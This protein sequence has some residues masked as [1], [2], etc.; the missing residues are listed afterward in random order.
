MCDSLITVC[1][2]GA[3]LSLS[4]SSLPVSRTVTCRYQCQKG[5]QRQVMPSPLS[6]VFSIGET[7]VFQEYTFAL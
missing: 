6:L 4:F 5:K 2:K 3:R 1:H 7:R